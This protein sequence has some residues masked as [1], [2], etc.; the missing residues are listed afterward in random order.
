MM[1]A[2][3]GLTAAYLIVLAIVMFQLS[4]AGSRT[5]GIAIG[6]AMFASP[7]IISYVVSILVNSVEDRRVMLVFDVLFSV[8]AAVIFVTTFAREGDA[9][10][11]LALF[12]IPLIGLPTV[13][14]AGMISIFG[15]IEKRRLSKRNS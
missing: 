6:E 11:Q 13:A 2:I 8:F 9:Q 4:P 3:T 14:I 15:H 12:I 7:I 5:S 1:R 10:Y